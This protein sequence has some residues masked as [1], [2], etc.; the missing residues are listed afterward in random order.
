NDAPVIAA[1]ATAP[2]FA[3]LEAA[4]PIAFTDA[5]LSDVGYGAT[6]S[7]V[8]VESGPAGLTLTSA[9][10]MAL[11]TP[12]AVTKE[13]GSVDGSAEFTF[14]ASALASAFAY[15]A[16]GETTTL[17]YTVAIDDG[18]GGVTPQSFAVTIEGTTGGP[19]VVSEVTFPDDVFN[20]VLG[21][22]GPDS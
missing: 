10:L 15:L 16:D 6:V 11:V 12:G 3:G 13:A 9:E 18:E 5:D 8:Y 1:A 14:S 17:V 7:D 22:S 19:A 2:S 21:T 4:I 20:V